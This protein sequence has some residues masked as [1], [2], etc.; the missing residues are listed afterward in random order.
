MTLKS[1]KAASHHDPFT[2]LRAQ[3]DQERLRARRGPGH[4]NDLLDDDQGNSQTGLYSDEMMVDA[5]ARNTPKHQN[6]RG[7]RR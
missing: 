7:W 3:A 6:Q 5:P 2:A 4:L 1:P